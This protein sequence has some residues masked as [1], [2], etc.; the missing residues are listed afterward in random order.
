MNNSNNILTFIILFKQI[1]DDAEDCVWKTFPMYRGRKL[2]YTK[3]KNSC[4]PGKATNRKC[5]EKRGFLTIHRKKPK[6]HSTS[7]PKLKVL[8]R[9]KKPPLSISM[10]KK[11]WLKPHL[12]ESTFYLHNRSNK[13]QRYPN[14][15]HLG[16]TAIPHRHKSMVDP[17]GSKPKRRRKCKGNLL[18]VNCTPH[19]PKKGHRH[20]P[21]KSLLEQEHRSDFSLISEKQ[22]KKSMLDGGHVV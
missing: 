11:F 21:S 4:K 2:I 8:L 3:Y 17:E 5:L 16:T 14:P 15:S 6:P 20:R 19:R 9:F 13:G 1:R 7:P 18:Q 22:P 12:N 10:P